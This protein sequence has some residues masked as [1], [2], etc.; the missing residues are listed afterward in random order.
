MSAQNTQEPRLS[1]LYAKGP[2]QKVL[3]LTVIASHIY[4]V[5]YHALDTDINS[6]NLHG[7]LTR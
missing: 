4:C 3:L 1:T 6:F 5:F 2:V 7:N